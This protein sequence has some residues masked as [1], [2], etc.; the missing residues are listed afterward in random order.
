MSI[1]YISPA[2]PPWKDPPVPFSTRLIGFI[3]ILC[4]FGLI[5][6]SLLVFA[7]AAGQGN[8]S[9][10]AHPGAGTIFLYGV[11]PLAGIVIGIIG[12]RSL[13]RYAFKPLDFSP[14]PLVHPRTLG[15]P[16]EICIEKPVDGW[17]TLI[18]A[19]DGLKLWAKDRGFAIVS[20]INFGSIIHELARYVV[21]KI[22]GTYEANYKI[23]YPQI[24]EVKV[25]GRSVVLYSPDEK[26]KQTKFWVSSADGERL[27]RELNAHI[28]S[29]IEQ[30]RH[31]L[32]NRN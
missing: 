5:L 21:K 19:P 30:W 20:V 14:S 26:I 6:G 2:V 4:M 3:G 16:M 7:F 12:W 10:Q 31:M 28:P 29:A 15:A 23:A 24:T 8:F 13:R 1:H 22:L 25:T 32:T 18:F 27:Y 9:P 17:G 11:A